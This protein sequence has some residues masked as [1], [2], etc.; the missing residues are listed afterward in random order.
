MVKLEVETWLHDEIR[1]CA[2]ELTVKIVRHKTGDESIDRWDAKTP[3][4]PYW[5]SE[6][7]NPEYG[8]FIFEAKGIR[9][10]IPIQ[11]VMKYYVG[12]TTFEDTLLKLSEINTGYEVKL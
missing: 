4:S 3:S 2:R 1:D 8:Y 11:V 7:A 5:Q 12:T 10:N 6:H 9:V